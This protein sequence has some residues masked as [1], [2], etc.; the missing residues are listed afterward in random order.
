MSQRSGFCGS[1]PPEEEPV[2]SAGLS[3]P[4]SPSSGL[5][6]PMTDIP[7]DAQGRPHPDRRQHEPT[8]ASGHNPGGLMPD[9]RGKAAEEGRDPEEVD[10]VV[11][12]E[13]HLRRASGSPEPEL[14]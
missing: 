8:P 6:S 9:I 3:D 13:D 7:A 12:D 1:G 14:P 11:D 4:T 10:P 5:L 2:D